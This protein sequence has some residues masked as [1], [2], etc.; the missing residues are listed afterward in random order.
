MRSSSQF[1][2]RMSMSADDKRNRLQKTRDP[3]YKQICSEK[4]QQFLFENNCDLK[5]SQVPSVRDFQSIFK[6]IYSFIEPFEYNKFEDD[7]VQILKSIKY[8]YSNEISKS[9]LIVTPHTWPVL[10]SML[11]WLVC[12]IRK[13]DCDFENSVENVFHEF[14]CQEYLQEMSGFSKSG[15]TNNSNMNPNIYNGESSLVAKIKEMSENNSEI[16]K[17]F[18]EIEIEL[19]N[20]NTHSN[21]DL[22]NK[23]SDLIG[24]LESTISQKELLI[25]KI[26]KY[27]QNIQNLES[28]VLETNNNLKDLS[29]DKENLLLIIKNQKMSPEDVKEMNSDK[30]ELYKELERIRPQNE[31]LIT[32]IS[33]NERKLTKLLDH[34]ELLENDFKRMLCKSFVKNENNGDDKNNY[35]NN[36]YQTHSNNFFRLKRDLNVPEEAEIEGSIEDVEKIMNDAIE[37]KR[38]EFNFITD[39]QNKLLEKSEVL[40]VEL[41][42]LDLR[43]KHLNEKM[44]KTGKLYIDK[45]EISDVELRK[46]RNEMERIETELLSLKTESSNGLLQSEQNLQR[47]KIVLDRIISMINYE[48]DEINK[49]V[50]VFYGKIMKRIEQNEFYIEEIKK[51]SKDL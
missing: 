7:I 36:N 39:L 49:I 5:L 10:L 45:K 26:K 42:E 6:F 47:A 28:K 18:S 17:R 23:R 13:I 20:I 33:E 9:Q 30:V 43:I 27:K 21:L 51:I 34:F 19:E 41:N 48:K 46:S 15:G 16:R 24:T 44:H 50:G 29:E 31:S 3:T 40:K 8:P 2:P 25:E 38:E 4:I 11:N 12:F 32:K 35:I 37:N 14:V 22:S 1:T